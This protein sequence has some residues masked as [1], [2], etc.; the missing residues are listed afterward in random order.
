MCRQLGRRREDDGLLDALKFV[1]IADCVGRAVPM[2]EWR[3]MGGSKSQN[4]ET[5][6]EG[7]MDI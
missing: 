2:L 4:S 1:A 5:S 6:G 3:T 7:N